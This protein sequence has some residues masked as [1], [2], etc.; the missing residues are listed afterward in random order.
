MSD[1]NV[2]DKLL[3]TKSLPAGTKLSKKDNVV[4][5][6]LYDLLQNISEVTDD[7]WDKLPETVQNWFNDGARIAGEADE[8]TEIVLPLPKELEVVPAKSKPKAEKKAKP[9]A[10]KKEKP[11]SKDSVAKD[12]I[13]D[14]KK[15]KAEKKAKPK[16]EKKKSNA[17]V[18]RE[19]ICEDVDITVK[20]VM[21]RL[22]DMSIDAKLSSVKIVWLNTTKAFK[23]A[24]DVGG[25]LKGGEDYL[26]VVEYED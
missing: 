10:K 17:Q 20:E 22:A 23:V 3:G 19:M 5:K 2:A 15:P 6:Y 4:Q 25:V 13:K 1:F 26:S 11:K 21:I 7:V 16:A 12:L 24:Y 18:I 14:V 8:G 9:K